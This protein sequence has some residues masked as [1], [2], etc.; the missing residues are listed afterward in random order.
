LILRQ[1]Y[2]NLP[3]VK[4]KTFA[5]EIYIIQQNTSNVCISYWFIL[6]LGVNWIKQ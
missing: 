3:V 2:E 1:A 6:I 5:L 4:S